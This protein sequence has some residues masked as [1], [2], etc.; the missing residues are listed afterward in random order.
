MTVTDTLNHFF[1]TT[2]ISIDI[3]L[4]FLEYSEAL[5]CVSLGNSMINLINH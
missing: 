2:S 5:D 3:T 1:L 4:L